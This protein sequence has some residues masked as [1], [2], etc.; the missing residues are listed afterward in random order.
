MILVVSHDEDHTRA[1]TGRLRAAG[2]EVV[3]LDLA[4]FPAH[5]GISLEYTAT[6]EPV[7]TVR[8][9]TDH[10]RLD[11]CRAAWWRRVRPFTLA[12]EL[13][14]PRDQSFAT[15]E[16]GQAVHGLF[17]A[18]PCAWVNPPTKDWAAHHKPYQWAVARR[19]GLTLPR[20]L[21]TNEPERARGF[22][23]ESGVGRTV[24]K[25]FMASA[26]AWRETRLVRTEDLAALESVRYAPV[27]F[28]E[29]VPG[30]DL[31][32]TVVG[33]R[34]FTTEIDAS[35]TSYP[36]DMRMVIHEAHVRPVTLPSP[37][38]GQLLRF[39]RALGLVYG[40]V[41]LRRR[42]DG[43]YVFLEVNPAGQWLFAEERTG[44]PITAEVAALLARLDG[45]GSAS[46]PGVRAA[47]GGMP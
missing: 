29:Y 18:L 1:V 4:D 9:P 30:V 39:M 17:H 2:R 14:T 44:L 31:R 43:E 7:H 19:T 35:R 13:S 10:V 37:V 12:R 34:V 47:G 46:D 11:Q 26:D 27:I 6:G 8:T 20:T 15:S 45:Q 38:T 5:G 36:A 42:P 33:D 16:T 28:Q 22:I 23:R 21:V 25:A 41:D 40:A 32:V 3:R 24:F